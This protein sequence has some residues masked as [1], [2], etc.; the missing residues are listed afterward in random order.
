MFGKIKEIWDEY[1]VWYLYDIPKDKYKT[2]RHWYYCNATNPYHWKL[3]WHSMFHNYPWDRSFSLKLQYCWLQ[4]SHYYFSKRCNWICQE[5]KDL[6]IKWQ[7]IAINLLEIVLEKRELYD[8][9]IT[10]PSH[11]EAY[12]CLVYVNMKNAKRFADNCYS[13]D[14]KTFSKSYEYFNIEQHELYKAKA[15]K[16]YYKILDQYSSIWWD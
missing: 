9:D 12:K 11:K 14:Y 5:H 7:Q 2:I 8:Y 15:L 10:K 13:H 6:I 1:V 16:L 3:V 4:K